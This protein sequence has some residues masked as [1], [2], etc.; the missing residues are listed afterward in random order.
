MQNRVLGSLLGELSPQLAP[1]HSGSLCVPPLLGKQMA[2]TSFSHS[3]ECQVL[4]LLLS[5]L[6]HLK[7][8]F[9]SFPITPCN[10]VLNPSCT[11][12]LTSFKQASKH[13]TRDGQNNK[14][15]KN[16]Q[17]EHLC[18]LHDAQSGRT[19]HVFDVV[20]LACSTFSF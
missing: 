18:S 3:Q 9:S 10:L 13:G 11:T 8:Y 16:T 7:F 15:K 5:A 2:R 19:C 20:S 12:S 14:K 17:F 6:N 1:A 4:P